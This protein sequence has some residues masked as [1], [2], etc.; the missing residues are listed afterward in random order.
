MGAFFALAGTISI[1][2][3]FFVHQRGFR[4]GLWN[5][6]VI[7]SVNMTPIISGYVI[8]DLSRRWSFWLLAIAFGIL[9]ALVVLCFPETTFNRGI[10]MASSTISSDI[11]DSDGFKITNLKKP[12]LNNCPPEVG[13]ETVSVST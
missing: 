3:I 13:H 9:F 8:V 1:N 5:F 7:V 4:V 6:A 12:Y 2:D 10:A 11:T